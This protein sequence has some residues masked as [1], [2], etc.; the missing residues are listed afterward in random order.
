VIAG[1]ISEEI[2]L[3]ELFMD[4]SLA[5]PSVQAIKDAGCVGVV[6][7]VSH[8]IDNPKNLT[9][10]EAT[11][12]LGAGLEIQL[13]FESYAGR[14]K[15]GF[16]AGQEDRRMAEDQATALGY[17]KFC[18]IYMAV[19]YDTI[20]PQEVETYLQGAA[21][22]AL[23][24][25]G[26]YGEASI[27]DYFVGNGGYE[28]GWQTSGWSHGVVSDKA[29]LLQYEYRS[30]WDL[31]KVLRTSPTWT[32]VP[33]PTQDRVPVNDGRMVQVIPGGKITL[34]YGS[35]L[36]NP[37]TGHSYWK[38]GY[39][40]GDDWNGPGDDHGM[41]V[42]APVEG[43]VVGAGLNIWPINAYG[44]QVVI[45]DVLGDHT[46]VCHL[47]RVIA[48]KGQKVYAGQVVGTVG[49]TGTG[50]HG[51]HTH[52][53]RRHDPFGYWDHE[54]PLYDYPR[55]TSK[56]VID[57]NE[58]VKGSHCASVYWLQRA[59]NQV[60]LTG[61]KNLRVSGTFG[62]QTLA[63]VKRFQLEKCHDTADGLLGPKQLSKLIELSSITLGAS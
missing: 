7:Y 54:K 43:T 26:V 8:K 29:H 3:A 37:A 44:N 30:Q 55:P 39:H 50:A 14:S 12:L 33:P 31:N 20:K 49:S 19:D 52:V 23:R 40:P 63:E 15:E 16:A 38:A 28:F 35:K 41:D 48:T 11:R 10:G 53:E 47:A 22:L 62:D 45:R 1:S 9:I 60:S 32:I 42:C 27:I 17:P 51:D 24:P 46:A 34:P 25:S 61:G 21:S 57:V 18:P 56:P 6:R 58:L 4:Y 13:V 59:L 2:A 36:I 5:R